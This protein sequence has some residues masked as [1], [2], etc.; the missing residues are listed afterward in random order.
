MSELSLS[1]GDVVQITDER[2]GIVGAF[3]MVDEVK[4]WG[5]TGFIHTVK[6]FEESTRIYLRLQTG[7]F[8][9]LGRAVMMPADMLEQP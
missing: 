6:T 4:P 2:P 8:E 9:R 7:C 5:V 1:P 3:L